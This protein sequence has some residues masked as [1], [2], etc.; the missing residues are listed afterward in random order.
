MVRK[1]QQGCFTKIE[2]V[3]LVF[4]IVVGAGLVGDP[5]ATARKSRE[6][7]RRVN[8][9]GNLRQVGLALRQ[10]AGDNGGFF[11]AANAPG[12]MNFEP[13]NT[14]GLLM[15]GSVYACPSARHALTFANHSNYRYRGSGLTFDHT[16]ATSVTMAYDQSGNHPDN[17]WMNAVFVDGHVEGSRPDGG[18]GWNRND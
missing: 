2:L 18:K 7:A 15:D 3:I 4:I 9:A 14:R 10:Y 1:R 12:S 8:C 16:H 5:I 13:L 11:P 17:L 6:K